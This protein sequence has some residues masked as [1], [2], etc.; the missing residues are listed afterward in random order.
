[1]KVTTKFFMLALILDKSDTKNTNKNLLS[2][3]DGK[4]NLKTNDKTLNDETLSAKP[5]NNKLGDGQYNYTYLKNQIGNGRDITLNNGTYTYTSGDVDTIT[6]SNSCTIDGNGSVIDMANSN[7]RA[8]YVTA[9]S[10]TIK[11]LT[12]KNA[13]YAGL[14][15][16][17]Y[18]NQPGNV[19]N[20]NFNN[21]TASS[22]GGAIF[23]LNTGT[24]TN[25]NFNGNTGRAGGAIFFNNDGTV[26]NCNFN[27]NTASSSGGAI[28]FQND[29]TVTNCNF[30]NNTASSYGGAIYFNNNGTVTNCNFTANT[31]SRAGGAIF[32]N[33]VGTG[34]VTNCNFNRNTASSSGGAIYLSG[35]GT[36]INCNFTGNNATTGSAIR[37]NSAN[38]KVSNSCFLS[39]RANAKDLEVIKNEN[40]ITI[41]FKGNNNLLN[42]IFS[43]DVDFSNVTYWG[44][45]GIMNTDNSIYSISNNETGQNITI[46]GIINGNM[47]NTIKS[48]DA[49]GKIVLENISGDYYLT[50]C[51]DEDSY[52]TMLEATVTNIENYT[53]TII[54]QT[55]NNK[56]VNITA[57]SNIYREYLYCDL[58]FIFPNGD[59]INANYASNGTWWYVYEFADYAQYN[60]AASID[61]LVN[62]TINNATI[63]IERVNSTLTVNDNITFDYG[64][65][66]SATVNFTNATGINATVIGQPKAIVNVVNNTITV[67]G[68]DAGTYTLN[69]TTIVD[70]NHNPVTQT[71]TITVNKIKTQITADVITTTYN[72]NK[73]LVI[74]LKDAN[75]NPLKG[76]T[77]SVDLNGVKKY[78]TDSN[79]QVK[80]P[81]KGL[82]PK[83]YTAKVTFNGNTNYEKSAKDVKV[84]IKKA[85]SKI[86]AGKK[87]FK[88]KTKVKKYAAVL[89]D[90]TG[91]AI[92]NAKLTL[93]VKGKTYAAK[94]NSKGKAIFKITK[95][96]K[97]GTFKG[98][99]KFNGNTYYTKSSKN[100]KITVKASKSKTTFKTVSK[101]SKDKKTVKK[102]QQALKD[103][104]YYLTYQ[105]HYLKVDGKFESCT[106]RSVKQ[107]QSD[108]GLKV[109]G[110]VD[111]KTAKKLGII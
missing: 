45:D 49:S 77:I 96:N 70:D 111:A 29:G 55:T 79:G 61:G 23:F 58:I 103:H 54:S 99:I 31:A 8:F 47:I 33:N 52:Y 84:T 105:G 92:K 57:K 24:V 14:G 9:S 28:F 39:N 98:V 32:F 37:F 67:S 43:T 22:S 20:C 100:V 109:T 91:K 10:V 46:T 16:A 19:I 18:F 63:T 90:S 81:T 97:K 88:A 3:D 1:M 64:G 73:Y 13:N 71:A 7:K 53:V 66:G 108:H 60:I 40:N 72:V 86:T 101:G 35:T 48:T 102:I 44:A 6:I 30:I 25:C 56:T 87:T 85:A 41:I 4:E 62:V 34:S 27:N 94:T 75:G 95:L 5:D 51:H 78:T 80:V 50:F 104:G 36:V 93:K 38:N 69:V 83:T 11:N 68:L 110:K 15:G 65:S 107:F 76:I 42:A 26:T 2:T 74:T 82:A 106:E 12:I 21:N 59:Y 89:K 17:I